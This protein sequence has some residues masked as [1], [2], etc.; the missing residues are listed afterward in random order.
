MHA[1]IQVDSIQYSYG[2]HQAV[3]GI[4]FMVAPGE[5]LGFLGPNGAGKS[6]TLKMLT[7]QLVPAGGTIHILGQAVRGHSSAIHARM[8]V[9][10]EEKNLYHQMSAEEN[11]RFFAS[12]FG[13]KQP[14]IDGLLEQV[15]LLKRKKDRVSAYSKGMKQRLMIA[16]ALINDPAVLFLDE[17][18]DGL[19]PVSA[20]AIQNII[21]QRAAA[22]TAILLTTHDMMEADKLSD[23]VAFINEGLIHAIDTPE[24]LKLKHGQRAVV[25]RVRRGGGI[26][27]IQVPLDAAATGDSLKRAVDGQEVVTVH[28]KEASLEEIFITMTGRG[29]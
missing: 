21:R 26:E 8:G 1:A 15:D 27:E 25:V 4:S 3:K 24:A 9:S 20:Q 22:G 13:I 23:R 2:S 6:T 11:L 16:R 14:D 12:L 10:F 19:D 29:L 18:T 17:P 5:V 28:T 7:G